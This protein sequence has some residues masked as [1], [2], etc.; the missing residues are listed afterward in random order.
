[1]SSVI[2]QAEE[3][4]IERIR[5]FTT[6]AGVSTEG[7][8]GDLDCFYIMEN[9][10]GGLMAVVAIEQLWKND[11]LLRSLVL[12]PK[13]CEMAD[14]VRFFTVVMSEAD[15]QGL[16]ALQLITPSPEI[17]ESLEFKKV[18]ESEIP[19]GLRGTVNEKAEGVLMRR[20]F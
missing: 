13:K 8:R 4:D 6:S 2:R 20:E 9:D 14:V 15:K 3:K 5:A 18:P 11:G 16:D 7:V 17:F 10:F 19:E 12:D 1:M